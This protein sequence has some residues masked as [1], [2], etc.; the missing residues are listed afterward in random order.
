M[1]LDRFGQSNKFWKEI[2]KKIC[3]IQVWVLWRSSR[4]CPDNVLGTYQIDLSGKSL[5]NQIRTSP[6]RQIGKSPG[7]S[8]RIF[9]R[10][11]GNAGGGRPQDNLRTNICRLGHQ[12]HVN[13]SSTDVHHVKYF[14]LPISILTASNLKIKHC[15]S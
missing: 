10:R 7:R 11:H 5:E 8:N 9:S 2:F 12:K 3:D 14:H 15:H 13:Q 4:R 6:G 1:L